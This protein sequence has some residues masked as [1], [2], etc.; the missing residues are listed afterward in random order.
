MKEDNEPAAEQDL[1]P[2]SKL[3]VKLNIWPT[4]I[5][6]EVVAYVLCESSKRKT[7]QSGILD[8]SVWTLH[9]YGSDYVGQDRSL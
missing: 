6:F 2:V 4:I 8:T 3:M 7:I 9:L 5:S 1:D